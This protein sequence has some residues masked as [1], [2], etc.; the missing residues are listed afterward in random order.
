MKYGV[1]I[2]QDEDGVFV[3]DVPALPGCISQGKTRTE[4][5][6]NIQEA[7]EA[8]LESLRV[9]DEPVPPSIDEEVIEIAV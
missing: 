1:L 5:L 8:Y 6:T 3:A 9:H 4:A 2:E 7:I